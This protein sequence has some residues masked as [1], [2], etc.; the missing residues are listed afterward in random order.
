[1]MHVQYI[2]Y[3]IL[4]GLLLICTIMSSVNVDSQNSVFAQITPAPEKFGS[5]DDAT[6]SS[7]DIGTGNDSPPGITPSDKRDDATGDST[8]STDSNYAGSGQTST[9]Q[10]DETI[11]TEEQDPDPTNQL[12]EAIMNE[13][14]EA[15]SASGIFSP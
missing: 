7:H 10:D 14:N 2:R 3:G 1:M 9:E 5:D 4:S 8:D 6:D 15:L 13:V 12:V 11:T